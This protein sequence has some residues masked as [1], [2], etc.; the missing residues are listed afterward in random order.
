MIKKKN[1][2]VYMLTAAVLVYLV[3][4]IAAFVMAMG[5]HS[6]SEVRAYVK[7]ELGNTEFELAEDAEERSD[8]EG[9]TPYFVWK[10]EANGMEYEV[11]DRINTTKDSYPF[12]LYAFTNN[13]P[14]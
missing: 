12:E 9:G 10:V 6:R 14:K 1:L 11:V 7:H 3:G 4:F 5:P 8:E 13:F 2:W